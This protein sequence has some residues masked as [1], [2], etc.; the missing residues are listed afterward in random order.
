MHNFLK[1][2]LKGNGI[3]PPE[4]CLQSFYDNFADA[5]DV[6]WT[7]KKNHYEAIFYRNNLEFIVL[8][9][10]KGKLT[11]YRQ[12]LPVEFVPE[13]IKSIVLMKGE[14]MNAVLKNKGNLLEYEFIIRDKLLQRHLLIISDIGDLI[15]EKGL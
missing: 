12:K 9:T 5:V 7:A 8:F 11:E 3:A 2:I 13:A 6:E 15:E 10:L 4:V 14:I 1:K